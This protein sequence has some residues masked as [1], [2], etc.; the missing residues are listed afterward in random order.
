MRID[1]LGVFQGRAQQDLS[2]IVQIV[3]DGMRKQ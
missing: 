1:Y 3:E 2:H